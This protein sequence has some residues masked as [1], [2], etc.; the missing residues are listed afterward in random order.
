MGWPSCFVCCLCKSNWTPGDQI[1]LL[2][3]ESKESFLS[4]WACADENSIIE[5]FD[6]SWPKRA[7]ATAADDLINMDLCASKPLIYR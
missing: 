1:P 2:I 6:R 3:R 4:S 5:I 7:R